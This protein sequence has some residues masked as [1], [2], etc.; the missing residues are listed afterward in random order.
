VCIVGIASVVGIEGIVGVTHVAGVAGIVGLLRLVRE[1]DKEVGNVDHREG[2]GRGRGLFKSLT[3]INH[4]EMEVICNRTFP[5][6][7]GMC[8]AILTVGAPW[9]CK[10]YRACLIWKWGKP[11]WP[12]HG[13]SSRAYQICTS[14]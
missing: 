1:V 13:K 7:I 9:H 14:A 10:S 2:V 8:H 11:L 12:F 6:S 5:K 3:D 4:Y